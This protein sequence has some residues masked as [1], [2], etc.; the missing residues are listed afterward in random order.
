MQSRLSFKMSGCDAVKSFLVL[1]YT[2]V[3]FSVYYFDNIHADYKQIFF[4]LSRII[5][6]TN[7]KLLLQLEFD[8][9]QSIR[10]FFGYL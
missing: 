7:F 9:A 8:Q 4:V 5:I 10:I 3:Y 1:Y 6:I 2:L